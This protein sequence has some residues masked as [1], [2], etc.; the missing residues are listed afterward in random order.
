[1]LARWYLSL[2][3]RCWAIGSTKYSAR[4]EVSES[5]EV[6]RPGRVSENHP[7][8]EDKGE[9]QTATLRAL[10]GDEQSGGSPGSVGEETVGRG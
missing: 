1:M 6:W 8:H 2:R 7:R 3:H 5:Q 9:G 10:T 4:R